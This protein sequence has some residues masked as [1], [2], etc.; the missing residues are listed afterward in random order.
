M[1]DSMSSF[2]SFYIPLAVLLVLMVLFK[3]QVI[4]LFERWENVRAA[5]IEKQREI[6]EI[7]K[8]RLTVQ[9]SVI[10]L[11]EYDNRKLNG[12]LRAQKRINEINLES[13]RQERNM[14]AKE[15]NNGKDQ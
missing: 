1:F 5:V 3:E 4:D 10:K 14:R 2:S 15:T 7:Q 8:E 13:L 11:L 9:D 12:Q 6:I